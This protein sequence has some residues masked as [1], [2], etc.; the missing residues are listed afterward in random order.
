MAR[1]HTETTTEKF[2]TKMIFTSSPITFLLSKINY[3][4]KAGPEE[5][6]RTF[7]RFSSFLDVCVKYDIA[8]AYRG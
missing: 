1:A 7:A 5:S 3:F 2:A 6:R 8:S 4:S